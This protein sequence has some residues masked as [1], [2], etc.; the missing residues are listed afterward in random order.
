MNLRRGWR[1]K[2]KS[3]CSSNELVDVSGDEVIGV[4]G[5]GMVDVNGEVAIVSGGEHG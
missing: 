2:W 4:S 5:G 1:R 3:I